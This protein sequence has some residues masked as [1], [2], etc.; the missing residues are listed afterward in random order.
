MATPLLL[1]VAACAALVAALTGCDSVSSND[2]LAGSAISAGA[3][4]A[5]G[6]GA[7]FVLSNDPAANAVIAFARGA[8]GNLTHVGSTPTGG[9]GDGEGLNGTSNPIAI[10]P[11]GGALYAV[12]GGS[13]RVAA[14][15]ARG[16]ALS[17]IGAVASGGQRP[18]S[19]ALDGDRLYVLNAGRMGA[20]AA[21]V[22][23]GIDASGALVEIPGGA[24]PL[25][26]GAVVSQVLVSPNGGHVVVTDRGNDL[27]LVYPVQTDGSL[28]AAVQT[29]SAGQT[30]FGFAFANRDVLIV[31]EAFGGAP[32]ASAT[33]SYR[34]RSDGSADV[35]TAS[36]P[37]TE[38][39]ACWVDVARNGRYAYVTNTGSGTVT[40]YLVGRD[41]SLTSLDGDGVTATTGGEPLD[42][43]IS[44]R[45]YY[46]HA[47]VT[48]ELVGF[49]IDHSD[50][51]LTPVGSP[52]PLPATA[53]GVAAR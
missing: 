50:G 30:A 47:R 44:D 12:D 39:A 42:A 25:P 9:M 14:F 46:V 31:S 38:T 41:G 28:G 33:S 27:I 6:P 13:D 49:R 17:L 23:F 11:G 8:D 19:V 22:P 21:I 40:G 10:R 32:D 3:A 2:N 48:N 43:A 36:A 4:G 1:R 34:L 5:G 35:V 29:A 20:G 26:A 24:Q 51:S 7:V 52:A 16:T 15:H 37:T 18:V 53:V 45:F